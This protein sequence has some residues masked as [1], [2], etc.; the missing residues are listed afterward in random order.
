[1]LL[2]DLL[3]DKSGYRL[4]AFEGEDLEMTQEDLLVDVANGALTL[5][6][7]ESWMKNRIQEKP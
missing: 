3:L 6:A 2:L 1:L 5:R 7:I 4:V